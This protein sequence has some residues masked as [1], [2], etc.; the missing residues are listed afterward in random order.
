MM[1]EFLISFLLLLRRAARE[2]MT[3][4]TTIGS[5]PRIPETIRPMTR[6]IAIRAG[7]GHSCAAVNA[8]EQLTFFAN[9]QFEGETHDR[10]RAQPAVVCGVSV[11]IGPRFHRPGRS[12]ACADPGHPAERRTGS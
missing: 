10:D 9:G 2:A 4:M 7:V 11:G 1:R 5:K 6:L 8:V 12:F 3:M